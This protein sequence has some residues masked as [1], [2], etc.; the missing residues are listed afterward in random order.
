MSHPRQLVVFWRVQ[1]VEALIFLAA[2]FII[3]F[4]NIENGIY[5]ATGCKFQRSHSRESPLTEFCQVLWVFSSGVSLA[6]AASS[7]VECKYPMAEIP[8]TSGSQS[9]GGQLTQ[10]SRLKTPHQEY[11]SSAQANPSPTPMPQA[12][13]ILLWMK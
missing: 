11:S 6:P 12:R 4:T 10:A 8:K 13:L 5:V 7:W 3:I 1:P 2:V 9:T